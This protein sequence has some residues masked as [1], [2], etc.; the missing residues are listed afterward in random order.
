MGRAGM[1]TIVQLKDKVLHSEKRCDLT[2]C[3]DKLESANC[4]VI[5]FQ[6]W[7]MVVITVDWIRCNYRKARSA[8][9]VR[10]GGCRVVQVPLRH[11]IQSQ[12]I[13]RFVIPVEFN[14]DS[15][16]LIPVR[17]SSAGGKE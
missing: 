2:V 5:P 12:C 13:W 1:R 11:P 15:G 7:R 8:A 14:A 10:P 3:C 6:R 16:R 17:S 4:D 9:V